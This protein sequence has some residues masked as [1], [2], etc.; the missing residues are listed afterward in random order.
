M[1]RITIYEDDAWWRLRLA[2]RLE[3]DLVTEAEHTW[4]SAPIS[5][6]RVEI[7]MRDV[8]WVDEAGRYLLQEMPRSGARFVTV[9]CG[10]AGEVW[11]PS[12]HYF[13]FI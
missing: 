7:D 9:S 10:P 4:I 6:K 11:P 12:Q 8:T 5:D 3:G 13:C 2:G 1:L